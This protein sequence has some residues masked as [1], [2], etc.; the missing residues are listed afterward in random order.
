[1]TALGVFEEMY[2][3]ADEI[4]VRVA[5]WVNTKKARELSGKNGYNRYHHLWSAKQF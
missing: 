5:M 4:G 1:M 2:A 3:E